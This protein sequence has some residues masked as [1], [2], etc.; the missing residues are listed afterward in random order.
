[1][2][3][4]LALLLSLLSSQLIITSVSANPG[5]NV[6]KTKIANSISGGDNPDPLERI[7]NGGD[8]DDDITLGYAD[9]GAN[10]NAGSD[11]IIGNRRD[12][13]LNG[14][15]GNDT[16]NAHEGNDTIHIGEGSDRIDGGEGIDTVVYQN[17]SSQNRNFQKVGKILIVDYADNLTNVEFIQFSDIRISTE[18][19]KVV[20]ILKGKQE[21]K[22][23]EGNSVLTTIQYKI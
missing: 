9:R 4:P 19:L 23:K 14:G 17:K 10:G 3:L 6:T 1:M 8:T 16:I 22:V 15:V 2:K 18:T 12:N 21:I 5:Q 11:R 7:R 20:P 13:L